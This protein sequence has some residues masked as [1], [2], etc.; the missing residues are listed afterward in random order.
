ME[1]FSFL[2]FMLH[3]NNKSHYKSSFIHKDS[4]QKTIE[5]PRQE[6]YNKQAEVDYLKAK[7]PFP[8]T[9]ESV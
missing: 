9:N 8:D 7:S 1:S 4:L 5:G 3:T 2:L 6:L